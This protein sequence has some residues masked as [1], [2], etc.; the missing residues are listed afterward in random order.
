MMDCMT[1]PMSSTLKLL[2]VASSNMVDVDWFLDV[3]DEYETR[4]LLCCEQIETCSPNGY[5]ECNKVPE[6]YS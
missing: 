6:G 1:T 5:K 3:P 4:Y 2:S